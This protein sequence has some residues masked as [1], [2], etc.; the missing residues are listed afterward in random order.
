MRLDTFAVGS[1]ASRDPRAEFEG[2]FERTFVMTAPRCPASVGPLSL[3]PKKTRLEFCFVGESHGSP[4]G[5]LSVLEITPDYEVLNF[6][7]GFRWV[8]QPCRSIFPGALWLSVLALDLWDTEL[9]I[10]AARDG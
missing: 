2:S 1:L 6:G 10:L 9:I 4:F 5:K 3:F 7:S 8:V